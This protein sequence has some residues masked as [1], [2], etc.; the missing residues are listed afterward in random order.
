MSAEQKA[1]ALTPTTV[2]TNAL[3]YGWVDNDPLAAIGLANTGV[4]RDAN[5]PIRTPVSG[6]VGNQNVLRDLP[7]PR[8][9]RA[10]P[11]ITTD[12]AAL[13]AYFGRTPL[14]MLLEASKNPSATVGNRRPP[15]NPQ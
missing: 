4:R 3:G 2:E 12:E 7:R 11:A 5:A 1:A 14:D 15:A 10:W 8:P 9:G 13:N 6:S